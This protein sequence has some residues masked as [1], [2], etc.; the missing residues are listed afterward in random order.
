MKY[1]SY[2][3]SH[4]LKLT[5]D[6][7]KHIK[8][9][10]P[11]V[12]SDAVEKLKVPEGSYAILSG[13][14]GDILAHG[15]YSPSINLAFRVLNLGDRKFND[16]EV[17]NR[18]SRAIA[19]KKHLLTT[20]NKCFRVI[21]G[22][23][24]EL[25]GLVMDYYQGLIVMKLDGAAA[26]AFWKKEELAQY[27]MEQ[28]QIPVKCVYYKR[29]NKEEDKGLI[30]A[31]E[32]EKLEDH[33][34]LENSIRF[35]S[36]IID[37]AK[38]GFFLDQRENRQFIRSVS[39]DKTLLNLFGY[40]GG[41]SVYAGLGGASMVTTVDIAPNAIKASELNWEINML[42]TEKHQAI[43]VD[44]FDFVSKAQE[45]KSL[46]DIVITDPPSFAPN[47]KSVESAKDAYGKI[48][49]D[50][51]RLVKDGGFFA[52]SSCSGHISFESFFETVQDSL[53][54]ARR[55][56]KVLLVRGQPED[57]PFPMALPEMRYLKFLYIQVFKD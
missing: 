15:F 34:F 31:G 22:E 48:F 14:K 27:F 43:C 8:R 28:G 47:H 19:N 36:N 5:R 13:H 45:E 39:K 52:A 2:E 53:S 25:P 56:G 12:F 49:S 32:S 42:P 51:L 3:K 46:W 11:W 57:H 7:A 23:G 37:A 38:T 54:K 41:F 30:L 16:Q 20:D 1:F 55:R 6:L 9:G 24:D 29:K 10:N 4:K 40:T 35:R 33:E 17:V 26:E 50:S 21:N 18:L 44:A